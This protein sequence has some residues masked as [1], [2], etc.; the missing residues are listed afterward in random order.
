VQHE[1]IGTSQLCLRVDLESSTASLTACTAIVPPTHLAN[2]I[3]QLS[4]LVAYAPTSPRSAAIARAVELYTYPNGNLNTSR[5]STRD[6][7][8]LSVLNPEPIKL[9]GPELLH[10]LVGPGA[11]VI[12]QG[13]RS[14]F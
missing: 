2:I 8:M 12:E 11:P 1:S 6:L 13:P 14:S 10:D 5:E 9:L 3:D 4:H 7:A